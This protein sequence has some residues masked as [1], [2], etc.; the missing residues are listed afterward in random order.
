MRI[1]IIAALA[2]FG[3]HSATS[4]DTQHEHNKVVCYWNST[5][6]YRDGMIDFTK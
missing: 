3:V 6:F 4:V 5:A 2:V 1:L